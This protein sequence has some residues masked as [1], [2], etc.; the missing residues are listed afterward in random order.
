MK[1]PV[2]LVLV[3]V[4]F[5][6]LY[7]QVEKISEWQPLPRVGAN[8]HPDTAV[9]MSPAEWFW[10]ERVGNNALR[11]IFLDPVT[12]ER[13]EYLY[14]DDRVERVSRLEHA[15]FPG[16]FGVISAVLSPREGSVLTGFLV[17]DRK[18]GKFE[19]L[20]T[21]DYFPR[22]VKI[23]PKGMIW[24]MGWE[25]EPGTAGKSVEKPLYDVVRI[26]DRTGKQVGSAVPK[27]K[28][29]VASIDREVN[30]PRTFFGGGAF[31][32]HLKQTNTIVRVDEESRQVELIAG[33]KIEQLSQGTEL[34]T[35][36]GKTIYFRG[37]RKGG[38]SESFLRTAGGEWVKHQFRM[39]GTVKEHWYPIIGYCTA[40][41]VPV[42]ANSYNELSE[43]R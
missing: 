41:G 3:V 20:D 26:Y 32:F 23:S 29:Q 39:M 30:P 14:E 15:L 7:S 18:T 34:A 35:C 17:V 25:R 13:T 28:L 31:L 6:P 21:G 16:S 5:L 2:P 37:A 8:I 19:F 22:G 33:P 38:G 10:T 4:S 42:G 43:V 27:E 11:A 40:E 24:T 12:R 36:D 9:A 1:L